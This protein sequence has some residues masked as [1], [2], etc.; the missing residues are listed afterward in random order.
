[1]CACSPVQAEEKAK[2]P[3]FS[4]YLQ[5]GDFKFYL[6]YHTSAAWHLKNKNLLMI[7]FFPD[8]SRYANEIFVT[9][10]G[11][12]KAHRN[13]FD[14][15]IQG[16]QQKQLG[17]KDMARLRMAIFQLPVT[18]ESPPMGRLI[19]VSFRIGENWITRSYDR[20]ALPKPVQEIWGIVMEG[21]EKKVEK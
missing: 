19:I 16:S 2:A 7:S 13:V 20:N 11:L 4:K 17:E 10:G 21:S 8:D 3:D 14:H 6:S 12:E 15:A 9:E 1:M 18:S 5:T